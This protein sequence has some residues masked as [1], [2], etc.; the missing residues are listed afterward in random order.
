LFTL[1]HNCTVIFYTLG[2]EEHFRLVLKRGYSSSA[3]LHTI[4]T[5]PIRWLTVGR[6]NVSVTFELLTFKTGI[7]KTLLE[8]FD[9]T[10]IRLKELLT[11]CL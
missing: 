2:S 10:L 4:F 7:Y 9:W 3:C 1:K 8:T 11:K 6:C 5:N